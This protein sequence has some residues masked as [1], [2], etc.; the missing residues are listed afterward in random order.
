V[1]KGCTVEENT[2]LVFGGG[3]INAFDSHPTLTHC[4]FALNSAS[5]GGGMANWFGGR[6]LLQGCTFLANSADNSGGAMYNSFESDPVL[7]DCTF[8]E[9]ST[10]GLGGAIYNFD[11]SPSVSGGT[12]TANEA[13][14]GGGVFNDD[15]SAPDFSL[16]TFVSN[17]ADGHGGG[18]FNYEFNVR[19]VLQGCRFSGNSAFRGG[20]LYNEQSGAS[21]LNC[22][23][24]GNRAGFEGGA[25]FNGGGRPTVTNCI[26]WGNEA[27]NA[28]D[29]IQGLANV[30]YSCV[31]GDFPNGANIDADPQF[32]QPGYWDDNGTPLAT[33]DDF[34]VDGD[35]RL[36]PDSPCIDSGEPGFTSE[37]AETDLDGHPRVL[38]GRVDSGAYE[39]GIG[40]FDCDRRVNLA[41]F[42]GFQNCMTGV[43]GGPYEEDCEAL[44]FDNDGRVTLFDFA[45]FQSHLEKG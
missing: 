8:L 10:L 32:V 36:M 9:N 16:C 20:G 43:L 15:D 22:T 38:C 24:T 27:L 29:E 1:I 4:T 23:F 11:S 18:M 45:E 7:T 5:H 12:F 26:L 28:F 40:D 39:F 33:S 21:F 34:W 30:T 44:D 31:A 42:A 6:A 3:V 41:D 2:A 13:D 14:Y 19:P 25:Q 35:Y 17:R 37:P